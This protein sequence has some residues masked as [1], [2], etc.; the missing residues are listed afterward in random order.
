MFGYSF[1]RYVLMFVKMF[2][3]MMLSGK[4]SSSIVVLVIGSIVYVML[5][6]NELIVNRMNDVWW[7]SWL[8]SIVLIM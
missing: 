1:D 4:L 3:M 7:L 5:S 2:C 8:E 6:E